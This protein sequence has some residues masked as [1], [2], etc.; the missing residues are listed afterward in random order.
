M[1]VEDS[2]VLL[3]LEFS[4]NRLVVV[5][6]EEYTLLFRHL[7]IFVPEVVVFGFDFIFK[8]YKVLSLYLPHSYFTKF[9]HSNLLSLS[10]NFFQFIIKHRWLHFKVFL[11]IFLKLFI[12]FDWGLLALILADVAPCTLNIRN[13]SLIDSINVGEWEI[14][15]HLTIEFFTIYHLWLN[16]VDHFPAELHHLVDKFRPEVF[17]F[18][19]F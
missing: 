7:F 12:S 17:K 2:L 6:E 1:E 3:I 15:K 16:F 19:F 4:F 13:G 9:I 8:L 11:E 10:V 18:H 14:E 5:L